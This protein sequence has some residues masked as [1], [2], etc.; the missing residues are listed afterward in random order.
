MGNTA[1]HVVKMGAMGGLINNANPSSTFMGAMKSYGMFKYGNRAMAINAGVG[2]VYGGYTDQNSVAGGA[3]KGALLGAGAGAAG[4]AGM[5]GL[6]AAA[7]SGR[8]AKMGLTTQ[9]LRGTYAR[10]VDR[11]AKSGLDAKRYGPGF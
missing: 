7:D 3:F 4:R 10:Y 8:F 5:Y 6:R 9:S 2:A 11:A 1:R